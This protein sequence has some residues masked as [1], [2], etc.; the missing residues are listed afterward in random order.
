MCLDSYNMG[1]R[2]RDAGIV[3]PRP[4]RHHHA[5]P[6]TD[7]TP[8]IYPSQPPSPHTV[9]Y[10]L[11][12]T[13]YFPHPCSYHGKS[14][15]ERCGSSEGSRRGRPGSSSKLEIPAQGPS[16]S[17]NPIIPGKAAS[18]NINAELKVSIAA[19]HLADQISESKKFWVTFQE[20]YNREVAE[21]RYYAGDD[22]LQQIW[23]KRIEY[24]GKYK[25]GE[26]QDDEEF[27][28]QRM[29]LETCLDQVNEAARAFVQSRPR[30]DRS[31]HD[32]RHVALEK[33]RGAGG[34]V[35]DLAAKSALNSGAC[36]NLV[37]EASN[38]EKLVDSK[39]PD[40]KVLH[41][42]DR[43]KPKGSA[44]ESENEGRIPTESTPLEVMEVMEDILNPDL[45]T[46][47][48]Q[49]NERPW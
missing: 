8:P 12:G 33:I 15:D 41:R 21:I 7:G 4:I 18:V 22:I 31:N 26:N 3:Q 38:L 36:A 45:V 37:T 30:D 42:F 1:R 13:S 2:N 39:S 23:R 35:L 25:N 49:G 34:L 27:S 6:H 5:R 17:G 28:I 47:D 48:E 16:V 10:T 14:S 9:A 44:R 11:N 20:K 46:A 19:K 29:K 40:A 24:N 43:R 32:P